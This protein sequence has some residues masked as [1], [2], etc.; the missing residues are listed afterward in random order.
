MELQDATQAGWMDGVRQT[1]NGWVYQ[2]TAA[3][4]LPFDVKVTNKEGQVVTATKIV[5]A[6]TGDA[7]FDMGS[8]FPMP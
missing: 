6:L 3:L 7:K 2:S 4:Q 1:W 8:N 5:T